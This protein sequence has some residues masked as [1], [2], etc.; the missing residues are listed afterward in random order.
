[1]PTGTVTF[2]KKSLNVESVRKT[3]VVGVV[4]VDID[5]AVVGIPIDVRD[6]AVRVTR[7]SMLPSAVDFTSDLF[8]N[9]PSYLIRISYVL[10][11]E[12][13]SLISRR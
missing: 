5:L 12:I 6:V 10:S 11:L 2:D 13:I 8:Q 3:A 7:T 9:H 1:M 4:P